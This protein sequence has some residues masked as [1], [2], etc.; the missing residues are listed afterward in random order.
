MLLVFIQCNVINSLNNRYEALKNVK[1]Q[2]INKQYM[3]YS[4]VIFTLKMESKIVIL[5][6]KIVVKSVQ[7][8]FILK[9]L[10]AGRQLF[11]YH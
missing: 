2:D 6:L 11:F 8:K 7:E 5:G 4:A 1:L 10:H 3:S 9:S